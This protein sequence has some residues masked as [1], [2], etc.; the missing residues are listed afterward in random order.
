[1]KCMA[2]AMRDLPVLLDE[3]MQSRGGRTHLTC[4]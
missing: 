2:Y 4:G 1:M 3:L